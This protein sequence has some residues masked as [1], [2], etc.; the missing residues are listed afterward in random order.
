[1]HATTGA[2]P[3]ERLEQ[4]RVAL[5]PVPPPYRGLVPRAGALRVPAVRRIVGLQHPLAIYDALLA[6]AGVA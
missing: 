1:V 3:A 6:P 5:Q 2:A 4:E